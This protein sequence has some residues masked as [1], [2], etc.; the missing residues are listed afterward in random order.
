MYIILTHCTITKYR[1]H[2][3]SLNICTV[4]PN[5]CVPLHVQYV[6]RIHYSV[7][8][9]VVIRST[10]EYIFFKF[11]YLSVSIC[12]RVCVTFTQHF[13]CRLDNYAVQTSHYEL[14]FALYILSKR[15]LRQPWMRRYLTSWQR[16]L[17]IRRGKSTA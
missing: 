3:T 2:S 8:A 15:L 9:D 16:R 4:Y 14:S 11:L 7:H 5:D 1:M 10:C 13:P 12:F 17:I 6:I